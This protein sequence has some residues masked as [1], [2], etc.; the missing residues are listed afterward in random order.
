MLRSF[1]VLLALFVS[2]C[3]VS[4][5]LAGDKE[6]VIARADATIA[7][8]NGTDAEAIRQHYAVDFT[9]F[10]T[11]GDLLSQGGWS[12]DELAQQF[13]N[14]LKVTVSPTTH[15][16][17]K[18]YGNT[19]VSTSYITVSVTQPDGDTQITTRRLTSVF[20][21]QDGT[22]KAVHEHASRLTP[23]QSE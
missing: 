14:G 19:A 8:W 12:W 9:R 2:L 23:T 11:N 21:K 6:D 20:T 17:V 5:A 16:E 10:A 1:R 22:W 3:T 4:V 13:Q 7:A 15:R 18:V